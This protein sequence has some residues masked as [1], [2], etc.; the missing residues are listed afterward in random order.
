[1]NHWCGDNSEGERTGKG[2]FFADQQKWSWKGIIPCNDIIL[3]LIAFY[4]L[5]FPQITKFCVCKI[6]KAKDK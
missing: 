2:Y 1:M 5:S 6:D 4:L 3:N